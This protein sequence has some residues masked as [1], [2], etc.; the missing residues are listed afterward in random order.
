M[1]GATVKWFDLPRRFAVL[2]ADNCL[3][4][5]RREFPAVSG[6]HPSSSPPR[7]TAVGIC[8][9]LIKASR[10]REGGDRG[11]EEGGG[12]RG[13]PSLAVSYFARFVRFHLIG[14]RLHV[15]TTTDVAKVTT[16]ASSGNTR[17]LSG[18]ILICLASSLSIRIYHFNYKI[19]VKKLNTKSYECCTR[20]MVR[21]NW[22][23][24]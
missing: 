23:Q 22:I 7:G 24:V 12:E 19:K 11:R 4:A 20:C 15:T 3:L 9:G 1:G 5:Y 14:D 8:H 10:E 6:I 2:P 21:D 17:K 16:I 13:F 18:V